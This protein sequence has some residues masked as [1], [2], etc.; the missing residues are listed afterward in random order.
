M[1][2]LAAMQLATG[3]VVRKPPM[4]EPAGG[5]KRG[6]RPRRVALSSGRRPAQHGPRLAHAVR[7]VSDTNFPALARSALPRERVRSVAHRGYDRS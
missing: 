2:A 7:Y 5:V 6:C 1:T 3:A 4:N